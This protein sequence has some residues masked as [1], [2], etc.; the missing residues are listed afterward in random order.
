L[1]IGGIRSW[2][3]QKEQRAD[4]GETSKYQD[5]Y[6][7]LS[8]RFSNAGIRVEPLNPSKLKSR[9]KLKYDKKIGAIMKEIRR[10]KKE[11]SYSDDEK[12]NRLKEQREKRREIIE[13]MRRA[14]G[15]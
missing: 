14:L 9:I 10:I 8:A 7:P 2:A 4:S 12:Q 13:D 5:D 15:N 3:E 6:S 1:N 11:R